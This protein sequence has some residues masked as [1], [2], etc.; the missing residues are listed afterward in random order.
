MASVTS[1][2]DDKSIDDNDHVEKKRGTIFSR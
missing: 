2:I 1:T